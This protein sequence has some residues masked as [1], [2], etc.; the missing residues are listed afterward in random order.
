MNEESDDQVSNPPARLAPESG[1]GDRPEPGSH[2]RTDR[3]L[4]E[5]VL[6]GGPDG[7]AAFRAL[8]DRHERH[9]YTTCLRVTGDADRAADAT[10]ESFLAALKGLG[11]FAFESSFRTWLFRVSRNAALQ[12]LRRASNRPFVSLD[13][14][15]DGDD[16]DRPADPVDVG[17]GE[18]GATS[19]TDRS[20]G[21]SVDP[22]DTIIEN[23][24]TSDVEA[25]LRRLSPAHA[26]ILSHRYFGG[27]SYEEL[28]SLFE[29][30]VGTVKSRLSRAHRAVRPFIA[31]VLRKHERS[32]PTDSADSEDTADS[33]E[34]DT[35]T[36][37]PHGES[38][39]DAAPG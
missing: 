10:Q 17:S 13:A 6:A 22:S 31:Q 3:D 1:R 32:D 21:S 7:K 35:R 24:F 19:S 5:R 25:A 29:C 36:T 9:V 30:S 26:D 15:G 8:Y 2:D 18:P 28:A 16:R 4:I 38:E 23:E 34:S 20:A 14:P 12:Y 11:S 37:N 33:E 39:P 27:L